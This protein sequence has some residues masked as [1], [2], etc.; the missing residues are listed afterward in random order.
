M[1]KSGVAGRHRAGTCSPARGEPQSPVGSSVHG[2]TWRTAVPGLSRPPCCCCRG[3]AVASFPLPAAA[4]SGGNLSIQTRGLTARTRRAAGSKVCCSWPPRLAA[5]T[6][7]WG[8]VNLLPG[9]PGATQT[10]RVTGA[11]ALARRSGAATMERSLHRVS[12]GAGA[13]S[14]ACPSISPPLVSAPPEVA[15]SARMPR[16][17]SSLGGR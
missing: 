8:R 4:R 7:A 11:L 14:R 17:G 6:L 13:P 12:S 3:P 15:C 2:S 9:L 10:P 5:A 16:E 1:G